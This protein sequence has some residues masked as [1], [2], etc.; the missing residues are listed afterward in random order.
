MGLSLILGHI[1]P[2]TEFGRTYGCQRTCARCKGRYIPS[3]KTQITKT[4]LPDAI[5]RHGGGMETTITLPLPP[6]L[7]WGTFAVLGIALGSAV[8]YWALPRESAPHQTIQN[9]RETLGVTGVPVPIFAILALLVVG[10]TTVLTFGLFGL[11]IEV[12]IHAVPN[13]DK[14]QEVWDFRFTL[15]QL[16]A[17]TTVLGAVVALPFTMIRL[18]LQSSSNITDQEVLLISEEALFNDK[19]TAATT[20]IY[21]RRQTGDNTWQDDVPRRNSAIDRL[22]GLVHERP[23][24]AP[25]VARLLSVYLRELSGA[26]EVPAQTHH[27][28]YAHALMYPKGGSKPLNAEEAAQKLNVT[29]EDI[30]LAALET[31]AYTLKPR[32][33][34]ENAVQTL[35]RLRAIAGVDADAVT[36][37]LRAAN[38]QG[39]DF[40]GGNFN[41]ARLN[42]AQL[43]GARLWFAQ[44]QGAKL[45][46]AQLQGA[47]LLQA[48]MQRA[49]LFGA[50]MQGADLQQ[51]ELQGANLL[52]A[53]MQGADLRRA[54][55][56]GTT[57][58]SLKFDAKTTIKDA[59]LTGGAISDTDL[60]PLRISPEQLNTA[61]G[62]GSV[63][64]PNHINW[65]AHWPRERL[66]DDE[67]K[68]QWRAFQASLPPG[69]DAPKR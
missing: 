15:V 64:L 49:E 65:P 54:Q 33:D 58:F 20:D 9:F 55:M 57:L 28:L 2:N 42:G 66:D 30:S 3:I 59:S 6:N 21:S 47:K 51:A 68:N 12:V 43:Q 5:S 41:R 35:G 4:L 44:M 8:I 24:Q 27:Y 38:L 25:R 50:Q 13:R 31:W 61:F 22:E 14:P 17:L 63:T 34:M 53:E 39:I 7:L 16:A 45:W 52:D 10:L 18:R 69:W 62:D 67:F 48:Q 29:A 23:D 1:T 19:M 40:E 32:S 26:D 36:I 37:D 60:S 11:I 46:Q 56:Q